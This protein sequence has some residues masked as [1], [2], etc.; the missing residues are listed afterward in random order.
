MNWLTFRGA[1]APAEHLD[2]AAAT[3]E[4]LWASYN[5]IAGLDGIA[6]CTKLRVLYMSNNQVRVPLSMS[7][8]LRSHRVASGT[9]GR[10]R[11]DG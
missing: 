10:L 8:G 11:I 6:A 4:E 9:P 2:D 1:R 3:L 5:S 7:V